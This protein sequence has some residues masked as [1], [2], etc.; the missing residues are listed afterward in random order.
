M[1]FENRNPLSLRGRLSG[2]HLFL[3]TVVSKRSADAPSFD[4]VRHRA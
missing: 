3:Q 2:Y 4:L 1:D